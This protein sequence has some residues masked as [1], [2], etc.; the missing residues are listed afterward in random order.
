MR[1][2]PADKWETL[3]D[4]ENA[5]T[6]EA[7][8]SATRPDSIDIHSMEH[9]RTAHYAAYRVRDI[10]GDEWLV[11]V[12]ATSPEDHEPATNIGYLGTSAVQPSGQIREYEIA[13]GFAATGAGVCVPKHYSSTPEGFESLWLPFIRGVETPLNAEQW[14]TALTGLH[15]YQP[16]TEF[17]VFT[18]R[19]KTFVRMDEI[20]GNVADELRETYDSQLKLLFDSATQWSVIHGDAH[21]G[22]AINTGSSAVLFDFDTACWAPSV[23]DLTHLLNRAGTGD[24]TGYTADALRSMFKF[25]DQEVEAALALR[26]TAALVA[27]VHRER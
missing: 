12:G 5:G 1:S 4:R 18:N 24:N 9:L 11:R 23:W 22:N 26:R 16:E 2:T 10:N 13:S 3:R 8:I 20:G 27:K 19:A 25:T 17:P 21:A 14:Y 15:A 7:V 6:V